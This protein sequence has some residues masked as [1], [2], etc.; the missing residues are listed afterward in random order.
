MKF[1]TLDNLETFLKNIAAIKTNTLTLQANTKTKILE[2]TNDVFS[3]FVKIN[4]DSLQES[5]TLSIGCS[6]NKG[7]IS[8]LGGC[9]N[10][11]PHFKYHITQSGNKHYFS[12]TTDTNADIEVKVSETSSFKAV[13]FTNG[14]DSETSDLR[15]FKP[16]PY[17]NAGA[18]WEI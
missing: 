17:G 2:I 4:C 14:V 5:T 15:T 18:A 13:N 12:I 9:A 3:C 11:T 1:I 16:S 6:G 7:F 8:Q 10:E